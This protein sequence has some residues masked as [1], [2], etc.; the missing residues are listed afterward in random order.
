MGD[1]FG[2]NPFLIPDYLRGPGDVAETQEGDE[3]ERLRPDRFTAGRALQARGGRAARPQ[4]SLTSFARFSKGVTEGFLHPVRAFLPEREGPEEDLGI[5]G[6]VGE[7][8]GAGLTFIPLFKG[9]SVALKGVG[10]LRTGAALGSRVRYLAP[11]GRTPLGVRGAYAAQ[12]ALSFAGFETFAGEDV[13]EAPQRFV[14]G[15][16][17][18]LLFEGAFA[19]ISKAWRSRNGK[20]I[21]W[22]PSDDA[23]LGI[24]SGIIPPER[25]IPA[26]SSAP[27]TTPP[28]RQPIVTPPPLG[29]PRSEPLPGRRQI[30]I[31]PLALKLEQQ[32]A[33]LGEEEFQ[34]IG[35]I[36][37]ESQEP[38][39]QLVSAF[40]RM[41]TARMPG[42]QVELQGLTRRELS[43]LTETSREIGNIH[44]QPRLI[45]KGKK[46]QDDVFDAWVID[47]D[48]NLMEPE[49]VKPGISS[50]VA[51]VQARFEN[52]GLNFPPRDWWHPS[53]TAGRF[54]EPGD[55]FM[56]REFLTGD[57]DAP[58][59]F[60]NLARGSGSSL[61][62]QGYVS[63]FVHEMQHYMLDD[64]FLRSLRAADPSI[65]FDDIV[66]LKNTPGF[67]DEVV[68]YADVD[69]TSLA[70][71]DQLRDMTQELLTIRGRE[72]TRIA[73]PEQWARGIIS[74]NPEYYYDTD[75]L[76]AR[77]VELIYNNPPRAF[78]I[79]PDA[80]QVALNLYKKR[81]PE[82]ERLLSQDA[83]DLLSFSDDY[84]FLAH[85]ANTDYL[86]KESPDI[87]FQNVSRFR[88]QRFQPTQ[89]VLEEYTRTGI[90]P[91]M[92]FYEHGEEYIVLRKVSGLQMD[93]AGRVNEASK[94][95]LLLGR[96]LTTGKEEFFAV[97]NSR[98]RPT[99]SYFQDREAA[100][101]DAV[102]SAVDR[103]VRDGEIPSLLPVIR[104]EILED[105]TEV[106][107][108][109]ELPTDRLTKVD[110]VESW[111]AGLEENTL[112]SIDS[113]PID[114]VS[115]LAGISFESLATNPTH[116]EVV[117][118]LLRMTDADGIVK[119]DNGFMQAFVRE[120][121]EQQLPLGGV[122]PRPF[123]QG[124]RK[125]VGEPTAQA[126]RGSQGGLV[127]VRPDDLLRRILT[128]E[129]VSLSDVPYYM[130][131][132]KERLNQRVR[133]IAD[134]EVR[135]IDENV[136]TELELLAAQAPEGIE[137]RAA[138]AGVQTNRLHDGRIEIRDQSSKSVMARLDED[139][140]FAYVNDLPQGHANDLGSFPGASAHGG[141]NGPTRPQDPVMPS[142]PPPPSGPGGA[143]ASAK[144]Q[145]KWYQNIEGIFFGKHLT[146]LENTAKKI[147]GLGLGPAYTRVY[148]PLHNAM[149][150]VNR[151]LSET[152]RDFFGGQTFKD[153]FSELSDSL[154]GVRSAR[155]PIVTGHIEALTRPE[156]EKAGGL[157]TRA[158]TKNELRASQFIQ[159][160]G[161]EQ[162]VP[163]LMSTIRLLDAA[164][165][166]RL[167][168]TIQRM[169]QIE[170]SPE[171]EQVVR[172]FESFPR[173]K[174]ID[175]AMDMAGLTREER[176]VIKVIRD[177]QQA[178]KGKFS[179]NAVSRHAAAPPLKKG[180]KNGREQF[181]I[182]NK[183]TQ[184]ELGASAKAQEILNGAFSASGLDPSRFIQGYW[185]HL[186][187]WV[188]QGVRLEDVLPDDAAAWVSSKYRT[189]E[190][191][192]YETN[193]LVGAY[194]HVRS[195][196]MARHFNPAV[197]D[198]AS[199]IRSIERRD[200]RAG[201]VMKEYLSELQGKPHASFGNTQAYVSK[202]MQSVTGKKPPDDLVQNVTSGLAA[203]T[204][205]A[206]LPFRPA[207]IARNFYESFI[208]VAPRT[209]VGNFMRGLRY[210]TSPE[211]RREAFEVAKRAGAIRPGTT[212]LRS[213][214]S[215][216][217]ILGHQAPSVLGR[218]QRIFDKGFEWYQ[219]AD[220]WGRAIAFHSQRIRMQRHLDDYVKGRMSLRDY[221]DVAKIN[222]FDP[223]DVQIAERA[224]RN[225]NYDEAINHLGQVLSRETMT[226]YGYADHPAGWNS[227]TGRLFGQFGTWPVQYKD[228]LIQGITRGSTKDR[229]EFALTHGAISGGT[230]SA[231]AAVGL[232]LQN[233]TGISA[234]YMGGPYADIMIDVVK[235][236]HGSD[237]E[238]SLA[239]S[240]L[241]GN[242]PILGWLETGKPRSVLLPGSFLLGDLHSAREAFRRDD[243]FESI[244]SGA[245][246]RVMRPG[247][248]HPLDWMSGF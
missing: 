151:E 127:T 53:T 143:A 167:D 104:H 138:R 91:G 108:R 194:K 225:K 221:K 6:A 158:M 94:Q 205:A 54:I 121:P 149:L 164:V 192:V 124:S 57:P 190:L 112:P 23:P 204:S 218:F 155:Y 150:R 209:G 78:E 171:A 79:G 100:V 159:D 70:V 50:F 152:S 30:A 224:L 247:E 157:M 14:R 196:Y 22:A 243:M 120:L 64:T 99:L 89:D 136:L 46:G 125:V 231:G 156:I 234:P 102:D 59:I 27:L 122:V 146:A 137:A 115:E 175:E 88:Q 60:T 40:T 28:P 8:A 68:S 48:R 45:R 214:H 73:E 206:L 97:A 19:T 219:S 154:I 10:L 230:I 216:E 180:F 187:K 63:T 126:V 38:R 47:R 106:A 85:S 98:L 208:K 103:V 92:R 248:S 213:I 118:T 119:N 174:T 16:G 200:T 148:L 147:E 32:T 244:M 178:Q 26:R 184:K 163:R 207:L 83:R 17:E 5:A 67:L 84:W 109:I 132:A 183:M 9:A 20:N 223:L 62:T 145:R 95:G 177:S 39:E 142:T 215:A 188:E 4:P 161:L 236:V 153:K 172:T 237:A 21:E 55:T 240:N 195:L 203:L 66:A 33:R 61:N 128:K 90:A 144:A 25:Q 82:I 245:G 210:V 2:R 179:I 116:A 186:R 77:A 193:P 76:F 168:S 81:A 3:D 160:V 233:W 242:I 181:A 52:L 65:D 51:A 228:Y 123:L 1:L 43:R 133:E 49:T 232:N 139:E 74:G 114:D 13:G 182:E 87:F 227:V 31:D 162:D 71:E 37:A 101:F 211:T 170:L 96:N 129:G 105:G 217:E 191:N 42:G 15:L 134:S 226:R 56:G 86:L 12:G 166:G 113:L 131:R 93:P 220:D 130:E 7:F 58:F 24:P 107:S 135:Q 75:E 44:V 111:I 212:K 110:D 185:P 176:Q 29:G 11:L 202:L 169:R 239:R 235:S 72:M 165:E 201:D 140:A 173:P 41:V 197:P 241:Y 198:A 18:G 229:I 35:R 199:A 246:V 189:G 34:A 238:K 36:V 141:G 222:T 117:N 69:A 80:A